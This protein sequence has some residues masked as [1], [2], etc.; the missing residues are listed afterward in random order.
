MGWE[1]CGL[2]QMEAMRMGTL[3]IITP[4]GG[5]KD[6]VEDDVTGFWADSEMSME[7]DLDE[8]SISSLARVLR[9]AA[10][11]HTAEPKKITEMRK[12]A[13]TA[14]S[15]FSWTNSALQ[16]EMVFSELG[17]VN[18]LPQATE[19]YVTLEVDKQIC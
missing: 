14:A 4:T 13:M 17:A 1:P 8:Q 15:E 10:T 5:L 2:V 3:P 12:A 11:A 6:T 7:V 18:V 19:S 16:Y 9:R